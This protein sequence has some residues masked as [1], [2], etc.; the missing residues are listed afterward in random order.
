MA[1]VFISYAHQDKG[2]AKTVAGWLESSGLSCYVDATSIPG[3]EDWVREITA[4]IQA[5]HAVLALASASAAASKWAKRELHEADAQGKPRVPLLVEPE[6]PNELRMLLGDAQGVQVGDPLD[7]AQDR[8]V[9]AAWAAVDRSMNRGAYDDARAVRDAADESWEVSV[10]RDPAGLLLA[11]VDDGSATLAGGHYVMAAK[12]RAYLGSRFL[13]VPRLT[14]YVLEAQVTKRG[15][16][17]DEWFGFEFGE[18]H[19]ADYH[20]LLLNGQGDVR[21][22]KYWQGRWRDLLSHSAF[23]HAR[24]GNDRNLLRLIRRGP[25]IH[26]FVNDLH[27]LSASDSDIR[28]GKLG[29]VVSRGTK[30][31]FDH[32][33]I[34]GTK[35]TVDVDGMFAAAMEHWWKLETL[36]A[37]SQLRSLLEHEPGYWAHGSHQPAA[38]FL[39]EPHP[40]H[41]STILVVVGGRV[42]PQLND[43]EVAEGLR[44]EINRSGDPSQFRVAYV[45]TDSGLLDDQDA[46][47]YLEC[48]LISVGGD[49]SNRLTP[50]L[51][52][53]IPCDPASSGG[54]WIH[55]G[56]AE[57]DMRAALWGDNAPRTAEAVR[58][59]VSEGLL[60]RF[61]DLVWERQ[62]AP[63]GLLPP[64]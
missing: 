47:V 10:A 64:R 60:T 62:G 27:A 38:A 45:V 20:Q 57:G 54:V 17:D 6:M 7:E 40:D 19:P 42:Y 55:H 23:R 11:K 28:G 31:A 5:C 30:V 15:G 2:I 52:Q 51:A 59:F 24:R 61:L 25:A 34:W 46:S 53:E 49:P 16:P 43:L 14:E 8:V 50:V 18:L 26:A 32:M 9:G 21:L 58:R 1:D 48:P 39:T 63:E 22:S 3:S 41:R 33:R 12:P 35:L 4:A 36:E 13:A 56:M 37:T 29:L 44:D